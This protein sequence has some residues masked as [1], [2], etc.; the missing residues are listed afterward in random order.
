MTMLSVKPVEYQSVNP[1]TGEVLKQ[2]ETLTDKELEAKIATAQ[3]CD[4]EIGI[5]SRLANSPP[6]RSDLAITR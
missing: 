2:F 3:K 1:A 4:G 5:Q 6:G